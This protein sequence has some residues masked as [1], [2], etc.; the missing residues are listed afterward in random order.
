MMSIDFIVESM[1]NGPVSVNLLHLSM[2][3]LNSNKVPLSQGLRARYLH[4][5][6]KT[7][8]DIGKIFINILGF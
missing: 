5:M 4:K 3:S 1:D 7:S 8:M 6:L 2:S